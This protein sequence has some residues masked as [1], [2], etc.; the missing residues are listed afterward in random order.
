M[1]YWEPI[2]VSQR[3]RLK[4]TFSNEPF[5]GV[6]PTLRSTCW[7]SEPPKCSELRIEYVLVIYLEYVSPLSDFKDN[8]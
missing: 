7:R 5:W 1:S 2:R 8:K 3:Q 4:A 6:R